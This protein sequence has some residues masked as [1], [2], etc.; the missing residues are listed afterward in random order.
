MPDTKSNSNKDDSNSIM[1]T[2]AAVI[3]VLD[4]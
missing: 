2:I 1:P 3:L 4:E